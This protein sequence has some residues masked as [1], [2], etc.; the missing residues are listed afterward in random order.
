MFFNSNDLSSANDNR[1]EKNKFNLYNE[2]VFCGMIVK[3]S[4]VNNEKGTI[5]C[6]VGKYNGNAKINIYKKDFLKMYP[7]EVGDLIE[8]KCEL[9]FRRIKSNNKYSVEFKLNEINWYKRNNGDT[10]R[11]VNDKKRENA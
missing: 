5:L 9:Y 11:L 3:K 4:F 7:F 10:R 8:G 2:M 1:N 6:K